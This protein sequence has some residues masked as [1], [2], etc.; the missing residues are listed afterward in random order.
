MNINCDVAIIGA[1]PAGACAASMLAKQGVDVAIFER[2]TFPRFSIGE[3]LLPQCMSFLKQA[4]LLEAVEAHGF[5]HKNGAVFLEQGQFSYFDFSEKF[6]EGPSTTFQVQRGEFDKIL[7]DGASDAGATIYYRHQLEA[8][9]IQSNIS[10]LTITD[11]ANEQKIEVNAKFILDA[12]G[13]GRVL[14]RLFDME[15]PSNFPVRQAVF[16]HINDNISQDFDRNKILIIV[17]PDIQDIWF[18]LIPFSNGKCSLGVVGQIPYFEALQ[19]LTLE[20]QLDH[21]V[22]Q[23][24]QLKELLVDASVCAEV[25]CIKGYAANVT[26]LYGERF[27]LLGNAGE[28][29]DPVFSSG[30]TIALQSSVLAAPLVVKA[31]KGENVDWET[32]YSVPLR[33]G[34]NTF[35]TFVEGWYNGDLRKV[36]FYPNPESRVKSMVCS[37]LAGYAWDISNPLVKHSERRLKALAKSCSG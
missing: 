1:G 20:E 31:L 30:V 6:S 26:S 17:H 23:V 13:F 34:I 11:L 3:S 24:P 37:I 32:E 4:G 10:V 14:P 8:V 18:W 5:Q 16:T 12:S 33:K 22:K 21:F 27:A 9:D 25:R 36:I 15:S 19:H 2:E 28:F 7:A 29:L 35:K